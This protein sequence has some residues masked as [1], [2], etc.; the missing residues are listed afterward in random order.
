[1]IYLDTA[2]LVKLI[3][4]EAESDALVDW[5]DGAGRCYRYHGLDVAPEMIALARERHGGNAACRFTTAPLSI[6]RRLMEP[7]MAFPFLRCAVKR[8]LFR[9]PPGAHRP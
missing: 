2:A 8:G 7:I 4:H 6:C 5:L 3:R 1:M 9:C